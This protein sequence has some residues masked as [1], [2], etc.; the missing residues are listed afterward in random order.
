MCLFLMVVLC[1]Q[2]ILNILVVFG[3][4]LQKMVFI[5]IGIKG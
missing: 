2:V 5:V 4:D 3:S 1:M